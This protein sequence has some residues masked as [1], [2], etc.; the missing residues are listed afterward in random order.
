MQRYRLNKLAKRPKGSIVKLPA[1]PERVASVIAYRTALRRI[2]REIAAGLR[3]DVLPAYTAFRKGARA[4][5]VADT[6]A[7]DDRS[8][9]A[10]VR[11]T[12]RRLTAE[13]E[14]T[15]ERI[16]R[17]DAQRHT[18][19]WKRDVKR[20]LG[21]DLAAVV[22]DEDLEDVIRD[23]VARN[24]ALI[25]GLSTDTLRRIESAVLDAKL[26]GR[27]AADL[28]RTLTRELGIASRR[29]DLIATDQMAKAT[30]DLSR[31]RHEQAGLTT[32]TWSTSRDERVRPRHRKLDGKVYKYGQPTGAEQGLPPGKPI[33][34][35]CVAIV[36][37][38]F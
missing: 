2:P 36:Q 3:D 27:S 15:V 29:A 24:V 30:S 32:Y 34:C 11:E 28:R 8:W 37:V 38:E 14:A 18:E 21:I 6:A 12:L 22:R 19:T 4:Q 5:R 20:T 7:F 1:I 13:V 26:S 9:F 33:R 17:L 23:A 35:R 31:V 10:R 16:L 25:E